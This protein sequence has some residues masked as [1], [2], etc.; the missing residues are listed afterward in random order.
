MHCPT[1]KRETYYPNRAGAVST[2]PKDAPKTAVKAELRDGTCTKCRRVQK[3]YKR[4]STKG[5]M[6][7]SHKAK[8]P[9]LTVVQEREALEAWVRSRHLRGV[10]EDGF[11]PTEL[12]GN[13]LVT[14]VTSC[15]HG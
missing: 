2:R 6:N 5:V 7:K 4:P 12:H 10:P 13:T 9:R 15:Y 1:C 14:T 3:G 8:R 11:D